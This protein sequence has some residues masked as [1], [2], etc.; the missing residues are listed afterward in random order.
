MKCQPNTKALLI[1]AT[2]YFT[3]AAVLIIITPF[4]QPEANLLYSKNSYISIYMANFFEMFYHKEWFIRLPFFIISFLNFVLLKRVANYYIQDKTFANLATILF[5]IT[6]GVFVSVIIANYATVAIFL[7]LLFI[8]FDIYQNRFA[9]IVVMVLLFFTNTANFVFYIAIT[10]YFYKKNN[11]KFMG[12]ALVLLLFSIIMQNYPIDGIPRGHFGQLLGIFG[13]IL[14]P[15]YFF[16]LIYAIYRLA[17]DGQKSL[18]WYIVALFVAV[19]MLL[20]IRQKIK[21]TDFTPFIVIGSIL[22]VMVFKNS[23]LIRL[24]RFRGAYY[25][26]CYAVIAVMFLQSGTIAMHYPLYRLFGNRFDFLKT[27]I[28]Q[29]SKNRNKKCLKKIGLRDKNLYKFYGVTKCK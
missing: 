23:L 3:V 25:K 16:A 4:S 13:A 17:K 19:A 11:F 15:F 2:L 21:I 18:L 20:S 26:V 27:S 1:F 9:Q 29:I 14:S 8:Y 22:V 7:T 5:L 6:P 12:I 24:K 28:Y 10:I